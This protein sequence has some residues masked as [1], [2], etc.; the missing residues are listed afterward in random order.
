MSTS[1][2]VFTAEIGGSPEVIFDLLADL[3]NYG[4]WLAGSRSFGAT[5]QVAPYPVQLGT[6]YLD[7]GP[8]GNRPGKVTEY[9]PPT[10][11][12]FHQTMLVQR[13]PLTANIDIQI[14]YTLEPLDPATRITRALDLTIEIPGPLSVA[15]PLIRWVFRKENTRLLAELKRYV[16]AQPQS[17]VKN[18]V[19]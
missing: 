14:R 5:T 12:G 18:R 4:R 17:G 7:A 10:H 15:E 13:G 8:A 11:L 16:E 6:T 1:H 9:D 19:P 2:P 3:P